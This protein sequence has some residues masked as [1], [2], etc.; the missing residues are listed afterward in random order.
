MEWVVGVLDS[1]LNSVGSST[2]LTLKVFSSIFSNPKAKS[3]DIF[4]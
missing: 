3:L 2:I 4:N 1:Q